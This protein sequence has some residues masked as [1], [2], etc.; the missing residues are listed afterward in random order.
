[1]ATI[2]SFRRRAQNESRAPAGPCQIII[3]PGVRY[4]RQSEPRKP[5]RT[6]RKSRRKR[7]T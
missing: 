2:L 7:A 6:P 1:M 3:F 4:E 5:R